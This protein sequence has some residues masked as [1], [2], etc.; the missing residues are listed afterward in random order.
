[1][2][3]GAIVTIKVVDT[4]Y[5]RSPLLQGGL[6]IPIQ[7]TVKMDY[8]QENKDAIAKY[9]SLVE[10]QYKEPGED[11]NYEDVTASVLQELESDT[12]SEEDQ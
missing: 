11:G 12:G 9:K 2:L 8:N 5:R 1:M 10:Q 6:E 7:V 3:Y 4:Q